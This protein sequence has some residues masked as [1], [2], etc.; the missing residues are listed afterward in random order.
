M[1]LSWSHAVLHIRDEAT[2]LDFYGRVLGFDVTD[3]GPLPGDREIIFMSQEPEEHHQIAFLS[4]RNDDDL[5]GSLAHLAFRTS[6][7]GELRRIMTA[8]D[9]EQVEMRLTS[10]GNTWSAYF[11][12]PEGNGVEIFA[13]TPFQVEQPQGK[14][15]D[16]AMDDDALLAWTEE[17]FKDEPRFG[18]REAYIEQ[19]RRERE[20]A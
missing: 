19:R 18:D 20:D 13:D 1:A 2:M 12:D 3:R 4:G 17:N 14:T 8:L 16:P 6:G 9:S 15:W 11:Q 7:L 10:H 5:P